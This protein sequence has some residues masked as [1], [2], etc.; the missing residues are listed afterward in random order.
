MAITLHIY[1]ACECMFVQW[2]RQVSMWWWI[3][4]RAHSLQQNT[5][6]NNLRHIKVS[7]PNWDGESTQ[8]WHCCWR[9]AS[10][11]ICSLCCNFHLSRQKR[12]F[13]LSRQKRQERNFHLSRQKRRSLSPFVLKTCQHAELHFRMP[14]LPFHPYRPG[15][16]QLRIAWFME[17][18]ALPCP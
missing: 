9:A 14:Q 12:N 5:S 17:L 4:G 15:F 13:H 7:A 18:P 6:C 3:T 1:I 11:P 8:S 2:Q 16:I 10:F